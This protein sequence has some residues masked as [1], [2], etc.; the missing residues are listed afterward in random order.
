M[1]LSRGHTRQIK[2]TV[3]TRWLWLP[4]RSYKVIPWRDYVIYY[5]MMIFIL[6]KEIVLYT[7]NSPLEA[8][9]NLWD[10]ETAPYQLIF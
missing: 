1:T 3:I 9:L 5:K 4:Y 7:G 2:R 6:M 8:P 10:I